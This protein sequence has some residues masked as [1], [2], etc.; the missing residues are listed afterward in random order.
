VADITSSSDSDLL[1]GVPEADPDEGIV[2][3]YLVDSNTK[4]G[5]L[6]DGESLIALVDTS[7]GPIKCEASESINESGVEEM[8]DCKV[9][10]IPPGGSYDCTFV[11]TVYFEGIP[12]LNQYGMILMTLLMLGLGVMGFRRFS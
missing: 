12:T 10:P 1:E 9:L 11:N 5:S 6:E 2:A 7:L 3:G 4:R 8:D